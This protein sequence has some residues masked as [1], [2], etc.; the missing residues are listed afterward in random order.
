MF[1]TTR[2]NH[3]TKTEVTKSVEPRKQVFKCVKNIIRT[4]HIKE[5]IK[6]K[7]INH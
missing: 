3:T 7:I 6:R 4:K 5:E 2:Q 1:Y